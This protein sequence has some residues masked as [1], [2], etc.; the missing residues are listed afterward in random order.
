MLVFPFAG[1]T[2]RLALRQRWSAALVA[3]LGL[4]IESQG[5]LPPPGALIVANHVSWVDVFAINALAPAAFIA[6]SEVRAWPLIGWLA[7]HNETVFLRRGSRGHARAVNA[8][9]ASLVSAGR[10]IAL[11]P[12]GTTSEGDRVLP[13]H[14]ALLQPAIE[15]GAAIVP[16][17]L[18]YEDGAGAR[19]LA[20]AYV[21]DT[22]LLASLRAIIG[23]PRLCVR[24]AWSPPLA[25]QDAD[26]KRLAREARDAIAGWLAEAEGDTP[27]RRLA[28]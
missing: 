20:A 22:S 9:L 21:G 11:F 2:R 8:E 18:R 13:F 16:V 4:R 14:S 17:A 5:P 23:A 10:V 28:A 1:A 26:R 27:R 7:A 15:A 12:E 19:S 25:P 24:L 3:A 6:K